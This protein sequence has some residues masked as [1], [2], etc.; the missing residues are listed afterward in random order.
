MTYGTGI[1]GLII[2]SLVGCAS[3]TVQPT[4]NTI[5]PISKVTIDCRYSTAMS[6]DLQNIILNPNLDTRDWNRTFAGISGY[7]TT[8]QK[9]ASAKAVLWNIR[10][11]CPGY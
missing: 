8:D 2:I 11:Q 5:N 3:N 7:L 4:P 6:L 10:T 9:V 1:V